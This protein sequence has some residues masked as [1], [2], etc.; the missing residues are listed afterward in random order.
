MKVVLLSGIYTMNLWI[1][2]KFVL[3]FDHENM[4]ESM[5]WDA[6]VK[7]S[8]FLNRFL[9]ETL[10]LQPSIILIAF[11]RF[12]RYEMIYPKIVNHNL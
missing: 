3:I 11:W 7:V 6:K 2:Y 8:N 1:Y 12:L 9:H 10:F 5:Y 4:R